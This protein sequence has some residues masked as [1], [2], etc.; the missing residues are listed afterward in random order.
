MPF[1]VGI[2]NVCKEYIGL[3]ILGERQL[4]SDCEDSVVQPHHLLLLYRPRSIVVQERGTER[5]ERTEDGEGAGESA[6]MRHCYEE[7]WK[8]TK[9][10]N[11]S[12]LSKCW[13]AILIT[14]LRQW[15]INSPPKG[16]NMLCTAEKQ[17]MVLA[18]AGIVVGAYGFCTASLWLFLCAIT[19]LWSS[20]APPSRNKIL[21]PTVGFWT[22]IPC[23]P[24]LQHAI[25]SVRVGVVVCPCM[26]LSVC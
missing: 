2:E 16:G 17:K 8:F 7:W 24:L 25:V 19:T 14:I 6:Q 12:H 26:N 21:L 3:A 18:Q 22:G 9:N 11:H 23:T 20:T 5:E 15:L 10:E 1:T 13:F 4:Q